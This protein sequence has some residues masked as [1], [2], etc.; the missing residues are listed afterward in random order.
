MYKN[1]LLKV[2]RLKN[3]LVHTITNKVVANDVANVV[4]AIGAS[5]F[6]ADSKEEMED[7]A[8]LSD[9]LVLNIG[10][11]NSDIVESM[12]LAGRYANKKGVPVVLDPVGV[13]ATSFR[14]K[15]VKKLF[16]EIN[17]TAIRG[18]AAEIATL[19]GVDWDS[20]GA[21]SGSGSASLLT[22]SRKVANEKQCIVA[23]SGK[24]DVISDGKKINIITNGHKRMAGITGSGCML[25]GISGAFIAAAN[26]QVMEAMITAHIV[27]GIAGERAA[28]REDVQ[29][30]GTFRAALIDELEKV[31]L[32]DMIKGAKLKEESF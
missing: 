8:Q 11:L 1:E 25:S 23:I 12:L 21:D 28:I 4:L 24:E 30:P 3:P 32:E 27:F 9:A 22:I 13:G 20:K 10:T 31:S 17:F 7:V 19:A 14:K 5:P 6:M 29:G 15:A 2:L 16:E 18:N 26:D